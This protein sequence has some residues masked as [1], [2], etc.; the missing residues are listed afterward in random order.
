MYET[1]ESGEYS[2]SIDLGNC[3]SSASITIDNTGF[4]STIDVDEIVDIRE[5]DSF[6]V[7][8]TTTANNPEYKWYI[9]DV[10][11][12]GATNSSFE[13]NQTGLYKAVTTQTSGCNASNPSSSSLLINLSIELI[14]FG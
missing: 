6:L 1:N 14:D 10:I 5:N 9:N 2:V 4:I 12:V 8:I 13:V 3:M 7:S 11:I